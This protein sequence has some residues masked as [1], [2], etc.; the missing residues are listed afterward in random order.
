MSSCSPK[1]NLANICTTAECPLPYLGH[2]LNRAAHEVGQQADARLEALG[3]R[4]KHYMVLLLLTQVGA[5][6][7]QKE[8]G[9]RLR[10]DRNTMVSL[11]DELEAQQLVERARDPNDRR[12]YAI[13]VTKQGYAV[14][15]QAAQVI[16]EADSKFAQALTAAEL[17]DLVRLLAKLLHGAAAQP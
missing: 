17:A 12:A 3:I 15:M 11:I 13:S 2:L 1:P 5:A 7:P 9:E 8:L 4:V 14:A 10:I 6:L 16:E